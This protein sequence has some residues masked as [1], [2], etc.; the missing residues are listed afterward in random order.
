MFSSTNLKKYICLFLLIFLA[1]CQP[2][3]EIVYFKDYKYVIAMTDIMSKGGKI[4]FFDD[5]KIHK[6]SLFFDGQA[7][8]DINLFNNCLY[9]HSVRI[10]KHFK[11]ESDGKLSS[12]SNSLNGDSDLAYASWVA[13]KGDTTLIETINGGLQEGGYESAI[14]YTKNNQKKDVMLKGSIIRGLIEHNGLLYISTTHPG[15]DYGFLVFDM[16]TDSIKKKL[17][18]NHRFLTS[19]DDLFKLNNRVITY[20]NTISHVN[21]ADAP[22]QSGLVSIDTNTF[23]SIEFLLPNG[24]I[25]YKGYVYDGRIYVLT[26]NGFL[27]QFDE[28]LNIKEKEKIVHQEL[29]ECY[30][31]E[32][33]VLDKLVEEN[34]KLHVLL[35][36]QD[37]DNN[38]KHIGKMYVFKKSNLEM[39]ES[40][41]IIDSKNNKRYEI[42]DFQL[43]N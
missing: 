18:F 40:F 11:L 38:P 28:H 39:I 19:Q 4:L 29:F 43:I 15:A 31:S 14:I 33:V 1:S 13:R 24:D 5:K 10:N 9:F 30:K 41:D 32:D 7:I 34:D 42:L 12:Y 2:K 21:Y 20:G 36:R 26:E 22:R 17:V 23:E 35:R 37:D 8:R 6:A 3:N 16:Q 25:I 27:Y